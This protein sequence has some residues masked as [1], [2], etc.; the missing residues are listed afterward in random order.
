M[1]FTQSAGFI[2]FLSFCCLLVSSTPTRDK[3][4]SLALR[5]ESSSDSI[6]ITNITYNG[7]GCLPDSQ[8]VEIVVI[9]G[10]GNVEI[11]FTKLTALTGSAIPSRDNIVYCGVNFNLNY[12]AGKTFLSYDS[13]VSGD[14]SLAPTLDASRSSTYKSTGQQEVSFGSAWPLGYKDVF[15]VTDQ[16]ELGVDPSSCPTRTQTWFEL[17]TTV[18]LPYSR[19]AY[20]QIHVLKQVLVFNWTE[21]S[22]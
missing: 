16:V 8:S 21:C 11:T 3:L 22:V 9:P 4:E 20:G 12:P 19:E 15:S 2:I 14:I 13:I 17:S 7:Y 6:Y 10:S 18:G 5:S 1:L